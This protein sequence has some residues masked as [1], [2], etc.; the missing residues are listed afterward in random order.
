MATPNA[1]DYRGPG[2]RVRLTALPGITPKGVLTQPL[3]L[4]VVLGPFSFSEE[5]DHREYT[6][7]SAG[8]YSVPAAGPASA[9]RLRSTSLETLTVDWHNYARWLVNPSLTPREARSELY[10]V[11][12]SRQPFELLAILQ[13]GS[14]EPEELR[15]KATLRAIN[16]ELRPGE[17]DTRYYSLELREWRDASMERRG[18]GRREGHRSVSTH[19]GERLPT[20]HRLTA[21]TTLHSLSRN[22]YGVASGWRI[23]ARENGIKNW[24]PATPIVQS[25]RWKVGDK[26]KI[27]KVTSELVGTVTT[28]LLGTVTGG[29][30]GL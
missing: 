4:P 28:E 10:R 7:V 15:M 19:R 8:E 16:R 26:V 3:Y 20:T 5:A 24:G 12:R 25:K 11:L 23:I 2:L 30:G 6:T 14:D 27:P 1:P 18:R 13:L 17:T 22:H 9:R 29:S 21:E